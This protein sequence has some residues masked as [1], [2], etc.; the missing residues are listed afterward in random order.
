MRGYSMSNRAHPL[1]ISTAIN[2][3]VICLMVSMS[4][5]QVTP[6]RI[7]GTVLEQGTGN[8]LQ[9]VNIYLAN[10]SYGAAT[11]LY[12]RYELPNV[13]PGKYTM[14][15]SHLGYKRKMR[16]VTVHNHSDMEVIDLTLKQVR[17]QMSEITVNAK[18][19]KEWKSRLS[20]FKREFIGK[21]A[22]AE[23]TAILNPEVLRF[24]YDKK[25]KFLKT[26]AVDDLILENQALGYR[27]NLVLIY[28]QWNLRSGSGQY[29]TLPHFQELTPKNRR[30]ERRW[31]Q[32]RKYAFV[33]SMRH[34]MSELYENGPRHTSFAIQN[35]RFQK[36]NNEERQ[37][38]Q[39]ALENREAEHGAPL[40][41]FKLKRKAEIEYHG[42]GTSMLIPFESTYLYVDAF[43][44]M[45][46]PNAFQIAGVWAKNRMADTLPFDYIPPKI[47]TSLFK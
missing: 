31:K 3:L 22:Y 10:T 5:A 24:Q 20:D 11:D 2:P 26:Y 9:G 30:Q 45:A 8:P 17:L 41:V 19:S 25:T 6:S 39:I 35:A 15:I 23:K 29:R 7:T 33:G 13:L 14:V 44:K 21:T 28:F 38:I 1:L 4:W 32:N 34:F 18:I 46:N 43:G 47:R 36:L 12:G 16:E 27:I 42:E 40:K 37:L